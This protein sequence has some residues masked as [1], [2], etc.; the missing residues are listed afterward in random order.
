MILS[1]S[2]W[3]LVGSTFLCEGDTDDDGN[4]NGKG[5]LFKICSL[6]RSEKD[7]DCL[8]SEKKSFAM[9]SLTSEKALPVPETKI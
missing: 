1:L 3:F 6:E 2:D 5:N 8:E 7:Q 9:F 4:D